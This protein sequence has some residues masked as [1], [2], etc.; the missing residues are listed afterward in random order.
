MVILILSGWVGGGWVGGGKIKNKDQ[1][2]LA[3]ARVEAELGKS[4]PGWL[5]AKF[6]IIIRN[7]KNKKLKLY[8]PHSGI[9]TLIRPNLAILALLLSNL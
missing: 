7:R 8:Q 3:E 9:R 2:C 1:L 5:K 4:C 6:R